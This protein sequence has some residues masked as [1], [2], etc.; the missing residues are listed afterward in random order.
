MLEIF[1]EDFAKGEPDSI[2]VKQF[3]R[4]VKRLHNAD[5]DNENARKESLSKVITVKER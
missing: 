4:E 1:N 5:K 3:V 2:F